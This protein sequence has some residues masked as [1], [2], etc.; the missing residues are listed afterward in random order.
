[1]KR[2]GSGAA[3][4]EEAEVRPVTLKVLGHEYRVRSDEDA[5]HLEKVAEY[6]DGLIRE[7]RRG[8]AADPQ[9]A[10]VMAALTI[11]SDLL[12]VRDHPQAVS[13]ERLRA[14]IELVDSV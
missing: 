14:L 6:V 8:S 12:Q 7:I 10:A 13:Q 4:Q 3:E 1:M 9:T 2:N 5:R 11:A